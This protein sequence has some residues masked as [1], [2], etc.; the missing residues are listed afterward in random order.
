MRPGRSL[1]YSRIAKGGPMKALRFLRFINRRAN[2]GPSARELR[3]MAADKPV[4]QVLPSHVRERLLFARIGAGAALAIVVAGCLLVTYSEA[5]AQINK[6]SK[7]VTIQRP[8]LLMSPV[9]ALP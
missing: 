4:R 3:R 2:R 5:A 7:S 8:A 9:G 6:D 1:K